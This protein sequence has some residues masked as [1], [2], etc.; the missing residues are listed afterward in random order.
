M[1]LDDVELSVTLVAL[2]LAR[3]ELSDT[4]DGRF[5]RSRF[6]AMIE[7]L[8]QERTDRENGDA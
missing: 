6:D 4:P 8:A 1:Y 5:L 2:E 3:N 7:R